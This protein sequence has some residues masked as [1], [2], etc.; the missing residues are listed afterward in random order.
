M[1]IVIF[2]E[3]IESGSEGVTPFTTS[4]S[5]NNPKKNIDAVFFPYLIS[6]NFVTEKMEKILL[7]LVEKKY[8]VDDR[9]KY[10]C[11]HGEVPKYLCNLYRRQLRKKYPR[12]ENKPII[13]FHNTDY[14]DPYDID[15]DVI[16]VR[17]SINRSTM[18]SSDIV[19]PARILYKD[20][21]GPIL[22][23]K[24][25]IGF[26]GFPHTHPLRTEILEEL[27]ASDKIEFDRYY[28]ENFFYHYRRKIKHDN[29]RLGDIAVDEL[30]QKEQGPLKKKFHDILHR[31]IFSFCPRGRGNY[32]IRFYE[33]LRAGRIPVLVDSDQVFP[34]EDLIDWKDI[35]ICAKDT[36]EMIKM[37][38][39]W[40]EHRDLVS[41]QK[42][43]REVWERF[44]YFESFLNLLPKYIEQRIS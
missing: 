26:C 11:M 2:K 25:T 19:K 14:A 9:R 30:L 40:T 39:D 23:K 17:S 32:S 27:S 13:F 21:K 7:P 38:H 42:R 3:K 34:C 18:G 37:V 10:D 4:Y 36:E 43:C 22:E 31:N 1:S 8:Q 29:P 44:L 24:I 20:W 35:V 12:L 33:T 16:V 28:T 41:V 5:I 15:S 6:E